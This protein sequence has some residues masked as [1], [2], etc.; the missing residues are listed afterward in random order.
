MP[1]INTTIPVREE[2][3]HLYEDLRILRRDGENPN[4][5]TPRKRNALW[6]SLRTL[7]W[8]Y[9]I[10]ANKEGVI[11]DGEQRLDVCLEHGENW[12]PVLRLDV[13]VVTRKIIRQILNKLRGRHAPELD[14]AEY[15]R[16]IT[17]GRDRDLQELIAVSERRMLEA[18]Q[19]TRDESPTDTTAGENKDEAT[20][21]KCPQ[22]GFEFNPDNF[23]ASPLNL[24]GAD[25][26]LGLI[27]SEGPK[28][29]A[30]RQHS[31]RMDLRMGTTPSDLTERTAA[32][33]EAFGIGVDES[34]IFPV[35]SGFELSY[36]D[37]DIVYVT[38]DSG[39]GKSQ[40][41]RA[42]GKYLTENGR[43]VKAFED[44]KAEPSEVV[45]EGV[46][47]N[48][49]EAMEAL[50]RAGLSEAFLMVRRF[51]ELSDG[52]NYRYRLAKLLSTEADAYLVDN[53]CDSLDREMARVIAYSV[54]KWARRKGA[55][56]AVATPHHDLL[57]DLNPDTVIVKGFGDDAQ[58]R[59]RDAGSTRFSLED[60]IVIEEGTRGDLEKLE[61]FHYLAGGLVTKKIYRMRLRGETIGV[62]AY[63]SPHLRLSARSR[64][65]PEYTPRNPETAQRVNREIIR[66][67]RV[68]VHPKYR[69]AGLATRLV[70]ETLPKTGYPIVETLAAMARYNPFF[71]KASMTKAGTTQFSAEQRT[72]R[73]TVTEL[74]GNLSLMASPR[75]RQVF[76]DGLTPQQVGR[77]A[78]AL[79]L[80]Y[81]RIE[82]Q[83]N[84]GRNST[85]TYLRE[86]ME[87]GLQSIL[88]NLL[89]TERVYLYWRR[90]ET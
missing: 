26:Q 5:M 74:G 68:I 18:I 85:R 78:H 77:L 15:Q 84:V 53:F 9:P 54:Q 27:L 23:R 8:L 1:E 25:D 31:V 61:Q 81:D 88:G 35:L 86:L 56:V 29:A 41:L 28:P 75:A 52:Q 55:M 39:G 65:F 22:C 14:A 3:R 47:G 72:L 11:G 17:A 89:A 43:R 7:G 62:A 73:K 64:V 40:L 69:G 4:T 34:K 46:G 48:P 33:A 60:E 59:Y 90:P 44:V 83:G 38:G 67:S 49:E 80:V 79:V 51:D 50:G 32:V 16:I 87:G 42:L 71:E 66:L 70:R 76:I 6:N 36:G 57:E 12:G 10:I 21:T 63:T 82:G 19:K 37:K 30:G 58:I 45:I 20:R 13:D 2:Y 24:A